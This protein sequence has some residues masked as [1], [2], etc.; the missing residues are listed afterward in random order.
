MELSKY[1]K[2]II[3]W[4]KNGKGNGIC[5][6]VAGSG[7]STTLKLAAYALKEAGIHPWQIKIIVF[8]KANSEDLVKKFGLDWKQSISTLHSAGYSLVISALDLK[9]PRLA[10][11]NGYKYKKIAQE[12]GYLSY[13]Q[14]KTSV[15]GSLLSEKAIEHES[16]FIKLLQL[17]RLTNQEPYSENV[18]TLCSHFEMPDVSEFDIVASALS[19][20][21]QE[22]EAQARKDYIFDY[23]DQIW[24]PVK[25]RI[26]DRNWFKPY[27]F[28]LV[29]ECQDLNA[30]Q[31]EL[32][33]MLAGKT[34]RLLY[35][36][37]PRQ[38]IYGFAGADCDSYSNILKRTKC[39]ELPLSLCYRCPKTHIAL[40]NRLFPEIPIEAHQDAKEG[41]LE[42][43][44]EQILDEYLNVGDMVLCR[45][46]APLVSLCI[47]LIAKGIPARVKGKDIGEVIKKELDEIS[48]MPNFQYKNF[49]KALGLYEKIKSERFKGL[50]NEEELI[51][52]LN[53][54]LSALS[55]IYHSKPEVNSINGLKQEIDDLFTNE[56]SPVTLATCHRAKGLEGER[57]FIIEPDK[58]P[59]KWKNQQ[60][61]QEIQEDNLL[62]VALT[63]SKSEL[64]IV[65][66]AQ[67]FEKETSETS[68]KLEENGQL[69][70][71]SELEDVSEKL[72]DIKEKVATAIEEL[73]A[74]Q[75]TRLKESICQLQNH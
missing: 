38:A 20:C 51:E 56:E 52:S 69:Q 21:L 61:W 44:K 59:L 57:I 32:S 68:E 7:K 10:T 28:V 8:G 58:M 6:A 47:H 46:T 30:A 36:G 67:W 64:Y 65:G 1:Q 26:G 37:D 33:L 71:V 49:G 75:K 43:V 70:A 55:A 18:A 22:G 74:Q 12:L 19:E 31:L 63:R 73:S 62:Y 40:V 60:E 53:D 45:K 27:Q 66:E 9:N 3:D 16:D 17:I 54:K 41:I 34:G 39:I 35:V 13:R 11:V 29:D 15:T 48:K 23:T 2:I 4:L 42:Q 25:W 24:L 72:E 5:N 50:D 14:G